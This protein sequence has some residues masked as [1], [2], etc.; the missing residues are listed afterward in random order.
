M[1]RKAFDML[2]ETS[3]GMDKLMHERSLWRSAFYF[4]MSI[5]LFT[6]VVTNSWLINMS[7]Q[8]RMA[9]IASVVLFFGTALTL[10][11]FTLHGIMETLGSSAGD[12]VGLI[13]LMGYTT[14]PFLVMTPCALLAGRMGLLGLPLLVI[15]F[16]CCFAWML[17]LLVKVLEEVYIVNWVR[18]VVAVLFSLLML[19]VVF[20][21]PMQVLF[22]L[23]L[24]SLQ[25]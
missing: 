21:F 5:G 17:Y 16:L 9:I 20:I 1:R 18:A 14:L 2:F 7:L 25:I 15:S 11:S 19:Y 13:C 3:S 8:I 10:Y 23:A 4:T 22:R 24:I 12:P 6:G